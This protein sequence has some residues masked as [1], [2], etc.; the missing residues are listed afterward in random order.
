ME[1]RLSGITTGI[2]RVITRGFYGFVIITQHSQLNTPHQ[3][4]QQLKT[5]KNN[6]LQAILYTI[7]T[8]II[9]LIIT[10]GILMY[11]AEKNGG[12][13]RREQYIGFGRYISILVEGEETTIAI[14]RH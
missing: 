9:L 11:L 7:I 2:T 4:P 13:Y 8:I 3:S 14:Y 12:S 6:M 10:L 1:R 5:N